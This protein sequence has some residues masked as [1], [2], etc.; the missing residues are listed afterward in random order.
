MISE[1][2]RVNG[3]FSNAS[4]HVIYYGG[5]ISDDFYLKQTAEMM[6]KSGHCVFIHKIL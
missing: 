1:I 4:L 6:L 2:Y 3:V 5:I